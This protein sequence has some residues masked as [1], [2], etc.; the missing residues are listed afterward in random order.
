MLIRKIQ[1][2]QTAILALV[3][4]LLVVTANTQDD[5]RGKATVEAK[6]R[7]DLQDLGYGPHKRNVLDLWKA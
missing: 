3:W 1:G 4:V 6:P 2:I 5:R 7:P